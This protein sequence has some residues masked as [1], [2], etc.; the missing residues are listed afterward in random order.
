MKPTAAVV[1]FTGSRR[2]STHQ[3]TRMPMSRAVEVMNCH[4]PTAAAREYAFGIEPALDEREIVHVLGQARPRASWRGSSARS[5]CPPRA[6][7]RCARARE[8]LNTRT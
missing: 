4:M 1:D 6:A 2:S 5:G 8:P 7:R 3:S